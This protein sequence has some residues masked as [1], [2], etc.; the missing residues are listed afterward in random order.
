MIRNIHIVFIAT[1]LCIPSVAIANPATPIFK[2]LS[3]YFGK[4]VGKEAGE[5][6]AKEVPEVLI[7]RVTTKIVREGGEESIEQVSIMVGKIGPDVLRAI[8]NAPVSAPVLRALDDLPAEQATKAAARLAARETG[9]ELA[10]VT[11]K[12]GTKA[13]TSELR[14]PGIGGQMV[15]LFGDDGASLCGK[16]TAD[17]AITVGRHADDIAKLP[18]TQRNAVISMIGEQSDRMCRFMG[19]FV[20]DNP[21]KVLFTGVATTIVLANADKV[22]GDAEL[23]Y[24]QAGNPVLIEKSGLIERLLGPVIGP[25]ARGVALLVNGVAIIGILFVAA[26]ALI[27]L[28][29]IWSTNKTLSGGENITASDN[30]KQVAATHSEEHAEDVE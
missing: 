25:A 21:G 14:H 18:V 16:L 19:Q 30:P 17:Q 6:M 4:S 3:R 5:Q 28:R 8:D 2:A 24:D 7:K 13:L 1:L 20:S 11:V 15:R 22:L 27:K 29:K 12:H 9:S 26:Y 10:K 23:V